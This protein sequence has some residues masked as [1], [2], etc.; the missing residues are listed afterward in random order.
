M[1]FTDGEDHEGDIQNAIDAAKSNDIKIYSIGLGSPDGVP[2]P[3]YNEEGQQT[4][5]K[6]DKD[7]NIV[8]SKLDKRH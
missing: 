3:V 6:R 5:F 2:I 4:G 7:G 8:L 1:I